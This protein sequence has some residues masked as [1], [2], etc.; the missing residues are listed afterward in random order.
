MAGIKWLKLRFFL[1][2]GW[3]CCIFKYRDGKIRA[4]GAMGNY[5]IIALPREDMEHCIK[6]GTFGLNRKQIIGKVKKGDKI[7]CYVTKECKIIAL[8]EAT[9]DYYLDDKKIFK[10][11]GLFPDR[12]DFKAT[13]VGP[14]NEMS[15][16]SIID[17]LSFVTNKYYWSVYFR[18]GIVKI[19]N[20]D[21]DYLAQK[22][23]SVTV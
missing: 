11:D 16:K 13:L 21:W 20:T 19:P 8:G 12:F 14:E 10:A 18:N 2:F 23:K 5:W 4:G 17:D 22:Q 1:V 6:I 9:S 3:L 7:A 15:V